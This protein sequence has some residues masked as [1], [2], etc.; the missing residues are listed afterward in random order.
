MLGLKIDEKVEEKVQEIPTEIAE[1]LEERNVARANKDW[2]ESDRLRD[3]IKEKGYIVKDSKD[4]AT[5]EKI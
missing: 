5:V 2:A 3:L 4:G 1:L